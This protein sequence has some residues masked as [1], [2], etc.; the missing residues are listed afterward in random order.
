MACYSL[1][2]S[3]LLLSAAVCHG[4]DAFVR[5]RATYYGSPK[6]LATLTGACGFGEYGTFVNNGE[7]TGVS[8][9]Y[10]N[11]TGCGACYQVRCRIPTH[12]S[13]EGAKVVV[14]DYGEGD[15]TDFILSTRAYAKLARSNMAAELFAYGVVD[16]E[17]KRIPC[18]YG[19][20]L[21]LKAHEHSK[22]PQ[23]LAVVPLYK[24]GMY[25]IIAVE[26]WLEDCKEWRPMR[27]VFGT[28]F[29]HQNPPLGPLNFRLQVV[30]EGNAEVKWVQL[31]SA[32]PSDWKAGIAYD[33][34][35]QLN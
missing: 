2:L 18:R 32:I 17:F 27:R 33:T 1:F 20:N 3:L 10:R 35:F 29:D 30:A 15:H 16:I 9:L 31:N 28:V 19:Y 21:F 25:D 6:C 14:T 11:G 13:D 24:E 26:I 34:D 8:R 5:S 7:I 4:Q 22:Y 12:C 23:Y